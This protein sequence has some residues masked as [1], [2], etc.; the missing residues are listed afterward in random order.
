MHGCLGSELVV[1]E[2]CSLSWQC[3]VLYAVG[4]RCACCV[5]LWQLVGCCAGTAT[6]AC[7]H[8]TGSGDNVSFLVIFLYIIIPLECI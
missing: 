2:L 7:V 6:I 1:T 8:V 5:P 4:L 3:R